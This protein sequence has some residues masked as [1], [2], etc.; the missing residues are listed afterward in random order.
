MGPFMRVGRLVGGLLVGTVG[1]VCFAGGV[2]GF[3]GFGAQGW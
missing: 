1:V 3:W 2:N